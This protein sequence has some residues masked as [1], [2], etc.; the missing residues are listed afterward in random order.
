MH[1]KQRRVFALQNE[2]S[3]AHIGRQ[4]GFF[5]QSVRFG[6]HTRHNFLNAPVFIA[7]NLGF[8]GFKVHRTT[9]QTRLQQAAVNIMQVHQVGHTVF[10]L[11]SL[12]PPGVG[13][14]R[15]HIGVGESRMAVHHRL[16]KLVGI[17]LPFCVD[18]H[19]ADH[20]QSVYAGV[21]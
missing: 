20:A 16:V 8:G 6:A 17:D 12:W 11:G 3:A 4:H 13:Q 2:V 5:N 21:Q 10:V 15:R 19:V 18:H 9:L 7:N 1:P 14:N